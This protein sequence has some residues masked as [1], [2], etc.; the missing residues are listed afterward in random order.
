MAAMADTAQE[1]RAGTINTAHLD[2]LADAHSANPDAFADAEP[3]LVMLARTQRFDDFANDIATWVSLA[4]PDGAEA[5]ALNRYHTRRAHLSA[6]FDGTG[7]LDATF[8]PVSYATFAAALDRIEHDLWAT[9]WATARDRYGHLA[10]AEDLCRTPTQRRHDALIE[11]AIRA[12]T[13]PATGRRPRPLITVL[14]DHPTLIGRVC[15]LSN[16][17]TITP[18]ELLPLLCDADI[19]RAVFDTPS[20]LLDIGTTRR[21]F[22]GATRRAVEIRDR[23]CQH[24][25]CTTPAPACDVDHTIAHSTKG[26]TA[27]TNGHLLCPTHHPGRTTTNPHTND[28]AHQIRLARTRAHQLAH[29]RQQHDQQQHDA[30][31]VPR[32][33][34]TGDDAS[35]GVLGGADPPNATLSGGEHASRGSHE[36]E[37]PDGLSGGSG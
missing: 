28:T 24:P 17:T 21:L 23:R 14:V 30:S 34:S 8:D 18:G 37:G 4:D 22:T 1:L 31:A 5:R 36:P 9:D 15:E 16:G 19:E 32:G 10:T 35:P 2:R 20:R 27:H 6:T 3:L 11:M 33:Q 7:T 12:T 25:S 29:Q 26:P 13:A